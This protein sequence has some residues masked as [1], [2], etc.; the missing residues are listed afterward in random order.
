[1]IKIS[2]DDNDWNKY[3]NQIETDLKNI[4]LMIG[5]EIVKYSKES[6]RRKSYNNVPWIPS[7]LNTNTLI[8]TGKLR[9]SIVIKGA[10]TDR[11]EIISDTPYSQAMNEGAKI[12]ITE[13]QRMFLGLQ[14]GMW[15]KKDS[16]L[17][18]PPRQF[19]PYDSDTEFPTELDN[20]IGKII[21]Q[22]IK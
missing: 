7:K 16:I 19:L 10:T 5:N 21:V 11:V 20:N 12:R 8:D 9:N 3:I 4:P 6:F 2:V 14:K 15:L 13:K 17:T 22:H 1:M 18:I